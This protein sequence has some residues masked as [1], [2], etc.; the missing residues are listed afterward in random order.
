MREFFP[1]LII[2]GLGGVVLYLL[3]R[4]KAVPPVVDRTLANC[5]ASYAGAGVSVPCEYLAAGIKTLTSD[6]RNTLQPVTQEV[7]T[8][9]SGIK[10]IELIITP[11]AVSHVAYNETKRVL[12]YI[13]PF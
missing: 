3:T 11:I 8:A 13:N 1:V 9:T 7:K 6:I 4:P 10:P 12:N 2:L 5:G